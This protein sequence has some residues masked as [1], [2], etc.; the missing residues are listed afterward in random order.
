[1]NQ[2]EILQGNKLIADFV[3]GEFGE[4][5]LHGN[6][7][8]FY[9]W[10]FDRNILGLY[11]WYR[12]PWVTSEQLEYHNNWSWLMHVVEKIESLNV[13]FQISGNS[14][15]VGTPSNGEY[16]WQGGITYDSKIISTWHGVVQFIKWYNKQQK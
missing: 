10:S 7:S 15:N 5:C 1:M 12:Q 6:I 9:A 2:E 4:I 3:G 8:S 16:Y 14:V 11:N 13:H